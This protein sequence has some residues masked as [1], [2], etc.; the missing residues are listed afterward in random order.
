LRDWVVLVIR[1]PS[2]PARHRVAIW[3]ELRRA[4]GVVLGPAVWALPDLPAIERV[5]NRVEELVVRGEGDLVRLRGR[6]YDATD[7]AKL[8][9]VYEDAR[10]DE[11][12]EFLAD[13]DKYLAELEK[14][15]ALSKYTLAELEE[16]DQSLERLRRWYRDIRGRDLVGTSGADEAD[17]RLKECMVSF[18]GY[19][20][21]VY[22]NLGQPNAD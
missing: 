17:R 11:W 9:S 15:H 21:A 18:D 3:R 2:E 14:E 13:C 10:R 1:V 20:D 19:A 6:G 12:A 7:A 5:V 16:E 4:G 8:T 22:K